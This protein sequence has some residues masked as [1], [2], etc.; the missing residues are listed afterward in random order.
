VDEGGVLID[1]G[2]GDLVQANRGTD[3]ADLIDF[4]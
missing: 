1:L 4:D 3:M 2:C